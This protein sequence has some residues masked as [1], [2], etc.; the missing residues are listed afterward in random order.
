MKRL[1]FLHIPK[2][3]GQTVHFELLRVFGSNNI[4]PVRVHT[5]SPETSF[6]D[7]DRYSVFSGHLDWDDIE[8]VARPRVIFSVL[9]EPAERIAEFLFLP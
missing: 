9:R 3:A 1:V 4:S 2:T 7:A 8:R 5:Q 6:P